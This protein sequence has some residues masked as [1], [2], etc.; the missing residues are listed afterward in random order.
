MIPSKHVNPALIPKQDNE[1]R[2]WNNTSKA[3]AFGVLFIIAIIIGVLT[4]LSF[5]SKHHGHHS[6]PL[7][8]ASD[9]K[10]NEADTEHPGTDQRL[11]AD[12][13][14]SWYNVNGEDDLMTTMPL[15]NEESC[16]YSPTECGFNQYSGYLM[17]TDKHEIHYWFTE[18]D[19]VDDPMSKPLFFWTNGG[20]G[21]SGMEGLLV[22]QGPWRVISTDGELSV[23]YN[24]YTWIMEVN[25]VFLE[26]PYGVGFSVVDEGDDP[27]VGDENAAIDMDAVIRD[28]ITKFPRFENHPIYTTAESWGLFIVY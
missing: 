12:I 8:F 6:S 16:S 20:P 22:E 18:A 27:V 19:T 3:I 10:M 23:E 14:S 24:P 21:C 2:R 15:L 5:E 7:S 17:A 9:T 4:Y 26:Q 1:S 11:F 25:M 28:F 13:G